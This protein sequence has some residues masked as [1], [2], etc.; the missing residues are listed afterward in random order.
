MPTG[1]LTNGF[2]LVIFSPRVSNNLD[3]GLTAPVICFAPCS[4]AILAAAVIRSVAIPWPWSPSA[5]CTPAT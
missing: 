2:P 5:T 3:P 4:S 1:P